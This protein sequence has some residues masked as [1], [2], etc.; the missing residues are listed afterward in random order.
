MEALDAHV[1][2][3]AP[4]QPDIGFSFQMTEGTLDN[5]T[6]T[7]PPDL[8]RIAYGRHRPHRAGKSSLLREGVKEL[9]GQTGQQMIW[10]G[11]YILY[12]LPS[13]AI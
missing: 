9:V 13:V 10:P 6:P 2:L 8:S 7:A 11:I 12:D 3:F 1:A 4:L 5:L